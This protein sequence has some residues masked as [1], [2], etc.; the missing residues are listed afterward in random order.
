MKENE[1]HY[2]YPAKLQMAWAYHYNARHYSEMHAEQ[3]IE[4]MQQA[5]KE[6]QI[7]GE[8]RRF[9]ECNKITPQTKAVKI[10]KDNIY[11]FRW[12]EKPHQKRGYTIFYRKMSGGNIGVIGILQDG[13][14]FSNRLRENLGQITPEIIKDMDR[15]I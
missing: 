1:P 14:D 4:K 13:A 7:S 9:M 11:S 8:H 2:Y 12:T 5:I 10:V 6:K 15:S 3:Y